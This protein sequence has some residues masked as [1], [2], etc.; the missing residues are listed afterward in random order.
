MANTKQVEA[1]SD[2]A[3]RSKRR[4]GKER[5]EVKGARGKEGNIF[6]QQNVH[7]RGSWAS[8][9]VSEATLHEE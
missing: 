4:H 8:R 3:K 1:I 2:A 7:A 5:S 9:L 6:V